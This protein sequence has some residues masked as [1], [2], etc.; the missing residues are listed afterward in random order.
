MNF[1]EINFAVGQKILEIREMKFRGWQKILIFTGIKLRDLAK[2]REI[3]KFSS[4][5]NI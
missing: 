1:V 4:R 3:A 2:N 5:K